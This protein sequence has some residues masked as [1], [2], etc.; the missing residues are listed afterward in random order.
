MRTPDPRSLGRR[1]SRFFRLWES[2]SHKGKAEA[3]PGESLLRYIHRVRRRAAR[4]LRFGTSDSLHAAAWRPLAFQ[5]VLSGRDIK[6]S[7]RIRLAIGGSRYP[8]RKSRW[9]KALFFCGLHTGP[10]SS[11]PAVLPREQQH[12]VT[13]RRIEPSRRSRWWVPAGQPML[14]RSAGRDP[15]YPLRRPVRTTFY[16][17]ARPSHRLPSAVRTQH[18]VQVDLAQ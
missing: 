6:F 12:A 13:R 1:H 18:Q 11:S 17:E 5:H 3:P 9:K 4:G 8:P 16:A 2:G 10:A 14:N 15:S 7:P